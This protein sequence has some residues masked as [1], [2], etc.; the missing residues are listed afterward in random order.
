MNKRHLMLLFISASLLLSCSSSSSNDEYENKV[1]WFVKQNET[2]IDDGLEKYFNMPL[3][4]ESANAECLS[5]IDL[6]KKYKV[7]FWT[8]MSDSLKGI[9][10]SKLQDGKYI[11]LYPNIEIEFVKYSSFDDLKNA[12]VNSLVALNYPS[13]AFCVKEDVALYNSSKKVVH[14]DSFITNEKYGM[15]LNNFSLSFFNEGRTYLDEHLYTLPFA[16]ESDVL[17]Y[18]KTFFLE[19]DLKVPSSWEEMWDICKKIKEI[20]NTA[21]PL[22]IEEESNLFINLTRSYGYPY[23]TADK[24][25]KFDSDG[26]KSIVKSLENMYQEGY[27]LT[28]SSLGNDISINMDKNALHRSYMTIASCSS[29]SYMFYSDFETGVTKIP[30][31]PEGITSI[32]FK[33]PSLC[34]F[35]KDDEQNMASW[36]AMKF[37]LSDEVLVPYGIASSLMPTTISSIQSS[38]YIDYLRKKGEN[39]RNGVISKAMNQA[40]EQL[41]YYHSYP[42]FIGSQK[43]FVEGGEIIKSVLY[44]DK[45]V[46][47]TF[48]AAIKECQYAAS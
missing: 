17:Y 3:N 23:V 18:N 27:L 28:Q 39:T 4:V 22:G 41:P 48:K 20:D 40:I 32:Y 30:S 10:T 33:G 36:L 13:I 26:S 37:L 46:D 38:V 47:A 2:F 8:T 7:S 15:N 31:S 19:N 29:S 35:N 11:P 43:A 14:L 34:M 25:F 45:K 12:I 42:S 6:N 5:S 16:K 21:I 1:G 24:E 9:I 44:L